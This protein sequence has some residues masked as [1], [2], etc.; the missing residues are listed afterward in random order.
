M[1]FLLNDQV[2]D[3]GDPVTTLRESAA[4]LTEIPFQNL[5]AGHGISLGQALFF[6]CPADKKP[7][8]GALKALGAL[9]TEHS[10]ANAALF[11]KPPN[12]KTPHDVQI[13]LAEVQLPV[14]ANL[15]QLQTRQPLSPALVNNSVWACA[16]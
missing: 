2:L 8:P 5:R 16:A 7:M 14:M 15:F 3:I 1:L 10:D 12:A 4:Q 11:V 6:H 9:I 13:R